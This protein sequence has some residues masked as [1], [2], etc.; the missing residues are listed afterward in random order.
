MF[1][2]ASSF[3]SSISFFLQYLSFIEDS[4]QDKNITKSGKPNLSTKAMNYSSDL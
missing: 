4:S 3:I 1:S 2:K